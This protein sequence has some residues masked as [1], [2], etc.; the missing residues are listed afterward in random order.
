[1]DSI[2]ESLETFVFM[3]DVICLIFHEKLKGIKRVLRLLELKCVRLRSRSASKAHV[4]GYVPP[5]IERWIVCGCQ[6]FHVTAGLQTQS[7]S[8]L[9]TAPVIINF[10]SHCQ[11]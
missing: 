1:M 6:V 7:R 10:L 3:L 8:V 2:L 5:N 11:V 9:R 4:H